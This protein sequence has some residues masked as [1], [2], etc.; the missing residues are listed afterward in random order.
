MFSRLQVLIGNDE[1]SN[2]PRRWEVRT[3]LLRRCVRP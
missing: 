3:M 2:E 1:W